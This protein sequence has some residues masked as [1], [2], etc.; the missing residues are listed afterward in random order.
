MALKP[1]LRGGSGEGL[2]PSEGQSGGASEEHV[3][4]LREALEHERRTSA[5]LRTQ[6]RE[7]Q[8]QLMKLAA[9]MQA[10][11]SKETDGKLSRWFRR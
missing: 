11:L 9:E 3:R 7:L 5:E 10:I 1:S 8:S 6:N 2:R 4:D